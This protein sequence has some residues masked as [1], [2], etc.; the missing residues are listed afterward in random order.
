M[1][2]ITFLFFFVSDERK[3]CPINNNN[4]KNNNHGS[5]NNPGMSSPRRGSVPADISELRRDLFSRSSVNGKTRNR[6]KTLRRRSSGGPEMFSG[7]VNTDDNENG[8][9]AGW[10]RDLS[11]RDSIPEPNVKRRCSLPVEVVSISHAGRYNF[12]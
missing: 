5:N 2:R 7:S 4:N 12:R 6:K 3:N 8:K 9:W 10:K 11:K 1:L